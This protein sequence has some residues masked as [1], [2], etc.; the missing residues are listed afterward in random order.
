MK[1]AIQ[2]FA[3]EFT[4][5]RQE[6]ANRALLNSLSHKGLELYP[7]IISAIVNS[8]EWDK[9]PEGVEYWDGICNSLKGLSG[10]NKRKDGTQ[11]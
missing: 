4:S 1:S 8:F 10:Y 5:S 3:D 6:W 11:F 2:F 7:T 9:T